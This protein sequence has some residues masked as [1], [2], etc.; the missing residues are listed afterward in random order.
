MTEQN[1]KPR[2][3]HVDDDES[4]RK[5]FYRSLSLINMHFEVKQTSNVEDTLKVLEEDFDAYIFDGLNGGWKTICEK[6]IE[7]K[8]HAKSKIILYSGDDLSKQAE[9]LGIKYVYKPDKTPY[10][11]LEDLSQ[12]L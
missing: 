1:T 4:V 5:L 12:S 6:L 7:L 3:L 9:S 11:L 2:I 10:I 8:P